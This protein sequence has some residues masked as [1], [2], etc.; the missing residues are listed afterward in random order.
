MS[1]VRPAAILGS[2]GRRRRGR[3]RGRHARVRSAHNRRRRR[4]RC[5]RSIAGRRRSARRRLHECVADLCPN[6]GLCGCRCELARP[7]ACWPAAGVVAVPVARL[8][9]RL[10]AVLGGARR[11]DGGLVQLLLVVL[12]AL[13]PCDHVPVPHAPFH[14]SEPPRPPRLHH[15]PPVGQHLHVPYLQHRPVVVPRARAPVRT[16]RR[17]GPRGRDHPEARV[18]RVQ[19]PPEHQ[20]VSVKVTVVERPRWWACA[21][22]TSRRVT[23]LG[24]KKCRMVGIPGKLS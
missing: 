11:R 12:D 7:V 9:P 3:D 1:W 15:A 17:R 14:D 4:R 5:P 6:S 20:S 22:M 16:R 21:C 23:D 10:Q 8:P 2:P 13:D 24:S 18:R 19:T